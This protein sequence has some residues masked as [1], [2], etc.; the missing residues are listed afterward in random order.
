MFQ[1][2]DSN[3]EKQV[4]LLVIPNEE[5]WHYLTVE[6][7]SALLRGKKS[8]HHGDFYHLYCLHYFATEKKLESHKRVCK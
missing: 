3:C 7:L 2:H 1:K 8:K 5:G 6:K 4:T